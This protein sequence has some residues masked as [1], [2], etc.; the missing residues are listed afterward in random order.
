MVTVVARTWLIVRLYFH[1]LSCCKLNLSR[2]LIM[3]YAMMA[4][5]GVEVE[6]FFHGATAASVPGPPHCRRFTIA[7]RRTSLGRMQRTL[8]DE[9]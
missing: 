9:I 1:C 6:F 3:K 8:P 4:R 7:L 2:F 5:R